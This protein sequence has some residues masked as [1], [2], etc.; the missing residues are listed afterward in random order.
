VGLD[1]TFLS[2]KEMQKASKFSFSKAGQK[3]Q[4]CPAKVFAPLNGA[5]T[6]ISGPVGARI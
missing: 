1:L 6:Q 3:L 5:T 4:I 2:A